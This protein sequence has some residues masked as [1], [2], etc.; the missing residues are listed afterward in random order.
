MIRGK[1]MLRK[2]NYFSM[3]KAE[4]KDVKDLMFHNWSTH[5]DMKV[6]IIFQICIVVFLIITLLS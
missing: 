4:W 5:W 2:N 1:K 6:V 3:L